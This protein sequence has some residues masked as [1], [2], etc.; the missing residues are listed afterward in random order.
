MLLACRDARVGSEEFSLSI[1][2]SVLVGEAVFGE[3]V[4]VDKLTGSGKMASRLLE[5]DS[6][7]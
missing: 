4:D 6:D 2:W 3:F 5:V 7:G 1:S